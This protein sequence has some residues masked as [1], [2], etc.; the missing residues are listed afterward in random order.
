MQWGNPL[1][2]LKKKK[3]EISL[4]AQ[5][6]FRFYHYWRQTHSKIHNYV[7]SSSFFIKSIYLQAILDMSNGSEA[8]EV[9]VETGHSIVQTNYEITRSQ[10]S[11]ITSLPS[12]CVEHGTLHMLVGYHLFIMN[13]SY[14]CRDC[15]MNMWFQIYSTCPFM[16]NFNN[17]FLAI[18]C[19]LYNPNVHTH[20]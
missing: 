7:R 13:I 15:I 4:F 17:I 12:T 16:V 19:F 6:T 18:S 14:L 3:S 10:L 11:R 5:K 20:V 8:M 2:S 1:F 9:L